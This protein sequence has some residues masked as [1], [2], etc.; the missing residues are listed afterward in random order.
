[1]PKL[2]PWEVE[3]LIYPNGTH[4]FGASS[5]PY[6]TYQFLQNLKGA[7]KPKNKGQS[8]SSATRNNTTNQKK[9]IGK[10][11]EFHN[12]PTHSTNECWAK[13]SLVAELKASKSD[14]SSN[15]E[16]EP[17]KGKQIIDADPSSIVATT[18][19]QRE[20]PEE[21]ECLFHSQMW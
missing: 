6:S 8:Q 15:P 17:E 11:C 10:W 16:S 7:P 12:S 21:G 18:K 3:T 20:N 4:G 14:A 19:I 5:S 13:Q 1:M 9:D 2:R